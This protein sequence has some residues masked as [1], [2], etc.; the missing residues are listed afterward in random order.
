MPKMAGI[1]NE[2]IPSVEKTLPISMPVN[3]KENK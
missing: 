2:A 3:F 1:I